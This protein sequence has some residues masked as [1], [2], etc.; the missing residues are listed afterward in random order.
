MTSRLGIELSRVACR[1]V[2]LEPASRGRA[3][4]RASSETRVLSFVSLPPDGASTAGKLSLL[5]GRRAS[6]VVWGAR[7]DHRQFVVSQGS[8][9]RMRAEARSRL[10][11]AGLPTDGTLSDIAPVSPRVAGMDRRAVLLASAPR[12]EVMAALAPLMTAGIKIRSVLTPA[13]ALQSLARERQAG[14]ASDALEAYVALE[15]TATC[16]AIVRGGVLLAA[17]DL[18]WGFLD[19]LADV[20]TP[21]DRHDI[22]VRLADEIAAFLAVCRFDGKPLSQVSVCGGLPDLR[23][24]TVALMERLDVE[25]DALDS[26]FR[27][28]ESRLPEPADHFHERAA[29]MRI[30]WAV[31]ANARPALDLFRHQRRRATTAYLSRAAVVAGAAAGL[32]VGWWTQSQWRPAG[33]PAGLIARV[34]AR[35]APRP[36]VRAPKAVPSSLIVRAPAMS[37]PVSAAPSRVASAPTVP[38]HATVVAPTAQ[39]V[40][41]VIPVPLPLPAPAVADAIAAPAPKVAAP[42]PKAPVATFT[43]AAAPRPVPRPFEPPVLPPPR[44]P[45]LERPVAFERP[46]SP[47]PR[48]A[49]PETALS[50]EASLGTILFG[51]DRALAIVDGRIVEVG[52]EVRGARVVEITSNAVMLRDAQGKLRRL[53]L[54]TSR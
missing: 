11:D 42:V 2:E 10:R 29:E 23:S 9:E 27:I 36:P 39:L 15:E 5:R 49:V 4:G 43:A 14:A 25:V 31:A 18:P 44:N 19:D 33:A 46:A 16:I 41:A 3:W 28:D 47:P 17:H 40:K 12:A 48:R 34:N 21:R 24:M 13:T 20:A 26:L 22:A 1:I 38:P 7:T 50:F 8:Y 54:S 51:P 35:P 53:S 37:A 30:A 52:D 32:G 45:P 6:V